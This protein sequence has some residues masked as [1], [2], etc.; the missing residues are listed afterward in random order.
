M[1]RGILRIRNVVLVALISA[2]ACKDDDASSDKQ[3]VTEIPPGDA[4]GDAW[5]GRYDGEAYT[6]ECQGACGPV[7]YGG[8]PTPLCEVGYR[9]DLGSDVTQ[10]D[11]ALQIDSD[12][13]GYI[14]RFRGGIDRDGTFDVGGYGTEFGGQVE[15]TGR[16]EGSIEEDGALVATARYHLRG[17]VQDQTIDCRITYEVEAE[18]VDDD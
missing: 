15:I 4:T 12:D 17:S 14:T 6:A 5:S 7:E 2:P 8:W 3:T 1:T 9:F 16:A 18:H 11:G 10:E 13:D